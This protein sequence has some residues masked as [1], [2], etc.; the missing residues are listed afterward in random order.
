M[1]PIL[2]YLKPGD[3]CDILVASGEMIEIPGNVNSYSFKTI[4]PKNK[5][6]KNTGYIMVKCKSRE[7][8]KS[9]FKMP[10]TYDQAVT[11]RNAL[12]ECIGDFYD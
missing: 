7:D 11:L 12:N 2:H 4:W 1:K 9:L 6:N 10:L 3:N 5:Q 8:N